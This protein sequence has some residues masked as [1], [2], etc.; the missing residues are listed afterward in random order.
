MQR[1]LEH[2]LWGGSGSSSE[3]EQVQGGTEGS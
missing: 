1:A 3:E 2:E